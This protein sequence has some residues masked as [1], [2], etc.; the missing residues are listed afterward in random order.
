VPPVA[1]ELLGWPSLMT[2]DAGLVTRDHAQL[3]LR[4]V[5]LFPIARLLAAMT[6]DVDHP[7]RRIHAK[8]VDAP[9]GEATMTLARRRCTCGTTNCFAGALSHPQPERILAA[10]SAHPGDSSK[11]AWAQDTLTPAVQLEHRMANR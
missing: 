8:V 3:R 7:A 4:S 11:L 9:D 6:V 10:A 1:L 5:V 2:V